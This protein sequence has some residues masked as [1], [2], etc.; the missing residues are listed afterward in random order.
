MAI[1]TRSAP[2]RSLRFEDFNAIRRE[3][4]TLEAAQRGARLSTSGNWTPG[5]NLS[6]LAAFV[7]YPYDGYPPEL[8]NP[9]WFIRLITKMMKNR[10]IHKS[11]ASGFHIPGIPAG[12]TGMV[13]APFEQ[14][15]SDYRAALSR[16]EKGPPGIP[17][18]ILGPLTHEEWKLLQCR[19]AE[20]HLS[21]LQPG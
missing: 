15:L 9:P 8:A 11:M 2:R 13:D 14:A 17:N 3:L 5:Q 1:N 21:F 16:M 10:L 19:H 18:P 6:H 4:E 20:L 7:K 12:T